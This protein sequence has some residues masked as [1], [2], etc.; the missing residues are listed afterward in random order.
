MHP[1]P[2]LQSLMSRLVQFGRLALLFALGMLL[3]CR[4][5]PSE[6]ATTLDPDQ[7]QVVGG[8]VACDLCTAATLEV[9]GPGIG[10][11]VDAAVVVP[12]PGLVPLSSETILHRVSRGADAALR[13]EVTFSN[14]VPAGV[15]D[16]LLRT[17]RR[18]A[19]SV[20]VL[21]GAL[22]AS[23]T[24]LGGIVRVWVQV[25]G[26]DQDATFRIV[27]DSGCGSEGCPAVDA[28]AFTTAA[29]SLR[30]G[31][32]R[33]RIEDVRSN[34]SVEAAAQRVTVV[35]NVPT[36][37]TFTVRCVQDPASSWA[38]VVATVAGLDPDASFQ[39]ACGP[40]SCPGIVP[41]TPALVRFIDGSL[42]I[43]LEGVA[44]NCAVQGPNPRDVTAAPRDTVSVAFDV[45]CTEKPKLRVIVTTTGD[46]RDDSYELSSCQ[47]DR[48]L[49]RCGFYTLRDSETDT[50]L[51]VPERDLNLTLGLSGVARNCA[52]LGGPVRRFAPG[53]RIEEVRFEV[54]C[55]L[56][57]RVRVSA[58]V[59]GTN[60]DTLFEVV[61]EYGCDDYYH[62]CPS[63]PLTVG[64]SVEVAYGPGPG[65]FRLAGLAS[66]CTVRS[67]NPAQFDAASGAF[68]E[69]VFDVLCR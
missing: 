56:P 49:V 48:S 33:V 24:A 26:E 63:V 54:T 68:I 7:F 65:S 4:E 57:A 12:G 23:S 21:Q 47:T 29:W 35:R 58:T 27:A 2:T 62:L 32:Y 55:R 37:L 1:N 38:R 46:S 15:Y 69:L 52:V 31:T 53:E 45:T 44:W 17:A 16:L 3:A 30:P 9:P 50:V 41:G 64:Q 14:V 42:R 66:N 8:P 25:A 39:L 43:A 5:G 22:V 20:L 36:A 67:P 61:D 28:Y 59:A 34:C 19:D 6:A 10:E 18:G 51:I 11:V 13:L 40:M 60:T